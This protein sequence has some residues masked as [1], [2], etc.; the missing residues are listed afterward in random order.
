MF[1]AH[2]KLPHR[3]LSL[4]WLSSIVVFPGCAIWGPNYEKPQLETPNDWKSRD[5]LARM[6][7]VAVPE[8]AWWQKMRD[9]LLDNLVH[10]ALEEN[11]TIQAA[12]GS[13]FKAKAILQQIQMRWVPKVDGGAGFI[14]T[15]GEI[16]P[17]T[18]TALPYSGFTA[19][20]I[21][22]Y[23]L[24]ILQQLRSLEQAEANVEVTVAAKNAVRLA[25]ISQVVGS[26]FGL[27]LEQYRLEL[28]RNLV[29]SLGIIVEKNMLAHKEGLISQFAL[30]QFTLQLA[31]ATAEIPVI[32]SNIVRFSN[33]L[34][35]L[36][37]ENPGAIKDAKISFMDIPSKG[38]IAA[39][40]PS[41]VL[42]NRPDII[43][44]EETLRQSNANI[45]VQT[46]FFFPTINLT[47]PVGQSSGSL[48][49]LF[50][51]PTSYW[52]YQGGFQVP[53]VNLGQFGAI[54][55]AK[56]Q[57]YTD[58]YNYQQTLR[59]AFA[60][61]DSDLASHQKYTESLEQ[62][63]LFYDTTRQRFENEEQ[64][65]REGLVSYPSVLSL[66]IAKNEAGIQ[67]AQTKY[68]QLMSIVRLYQD[69]GGGYQVN[70][71]ENARDLGDG[72]RFGDLF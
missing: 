64:R 54:K 2:V 14:S 39:N 33:T 60:S 34:H 15:P 6:D 22:N 69:L 72:H 49:N 67:A 61:V 12:I 32:E 24:N 17:T 59:N 7:G 42:K 57:Y 71:N 47:G 28:Q 56:A 38:I 43:A 46:T 66:R 26:Y 55:G 51:N 35:A 41:T 1:E 31:N 40:L 18:V 45:G 8:M 20:F 25:V 29:D 37:N 27:R 9:P 53:I 63:Q 3:I 44:A 30:R 16:N 4:L 52:Q 70:N 11:N 58:Y 23:E 48:S 10:Q 5:S 19:G 50:S 13:V 21:P 36:L 68:N 62:M 65:H